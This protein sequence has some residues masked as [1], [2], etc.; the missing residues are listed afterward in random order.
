MKRFALPA[1]F[2]FL[3]LAPSAEARMGPCIQGQRPVCHVWTGKVTFVA[4]GDTMYVRIKG[5]GTKRVRITGINAQEQ[6]R[7]SH[8]KRKR[9]GECHAVAAT[10]YL[11][12]MIRAGHHRV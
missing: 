8:V 11:G 5:V 9:R 2:A 7:Y 3:A 1:L 4:D 10:E 6:T 12:H